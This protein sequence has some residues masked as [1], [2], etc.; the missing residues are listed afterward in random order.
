MPYKGATA[1]SLK[2][3][4]HRASYPVGYPDTAYG[5]YSPE[6]LGGTE[7]FPTFPS[8]KLADLPA[9]VDSGRFVNCPL[10]NAMA[11]HQ[12]PSMGLCS[13]NVK[14]GHNGKKAAKAQLGVTGGR[15]EGA[16]AASAGQNRRNR[17]QEG[18]KGTKVGRNGRLITFL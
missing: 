7:T 18:K 5:V 3:R 1:E 6:A 10:A 8:G 9:T 17:K 12:T 11:A 16:S 4:V 15:V 13:N 14:K 2:F